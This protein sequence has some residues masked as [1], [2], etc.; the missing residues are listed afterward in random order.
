MRRV[1]KTTSCLKKRQA[2]IE[3]FWERLVGRAQS[4]PDQAKF[5]SVLAQGQKEPTDTFEQALRKYLRYVR[6]I[7]HYH[8]VF[9]TDYK[10]AE[11][12]SG[13]FAVCDAAW[14]PVILRVVVQLLVERSI[15]SSASLKVFPDFRVQFALSSCECELISAC[16]VCQE[17][18]GLRTLVAFVSSFQDRRAL[19]RFDMNSHNLHDLSFDTDLGL[20][21]LHMKS[22]SEAC[23]AC[24]EK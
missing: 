20:P 16:Q 23:L 6:G 8:N 21:A 3:G 2:A 4:R 13:I 22:D 19:R 9:P 7:A 17:A 18:M 11:G 24:V 10:H 12:H 14:G 1:G 5:L 15:G